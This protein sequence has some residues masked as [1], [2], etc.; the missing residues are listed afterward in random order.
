MKII[1]A[2]CLLVFVF[3]FVLFVRFLLV[4]GKQCGNYICTHGIYI[5]L[6]YIYVVP[7][8]LV[9]FL[10]TF[11]GTQSNL[12]LP[13][14]PTHYYIVAKYIEISGQ[15]LMENYSWCILQKSGIIFDTMITV[16]LFFIIFVNIIIHGCCQ[17]PP[18]LVMLN[19]ILV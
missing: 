11:S 16:S 13:P 4:I 17:H 15:K 14:P 19:H 9:F 18:Q 12:P 5:N 1:P 6:C 8:L 10:P 2:F 3:C 7:N